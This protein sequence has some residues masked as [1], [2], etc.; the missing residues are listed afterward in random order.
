MNGDESMHLRRPFY[1]EFYMIPL[2]QHRAGNNPPQ[3]ASVHAST[4]LHTGLATDLV[5][6][7]SAR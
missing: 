1:P 6:Q 4:N 2:A 5:R 7:C 3:Q